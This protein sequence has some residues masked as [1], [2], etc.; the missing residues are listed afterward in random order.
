ML[1]RSRAW[2]FIRSGLNNHYGVLPANIGT[3]GDFP[4]ILAGEFDLPADADVELLV[5]ANTLPAQGVFEIH[6]DGSHY[7]G[8]IAA[9]P[10]P[11]TAAIW[12]HRPG[13]AAV[14]EA[15]G[16]P[17]TINDGDAGI[18][19]A[20]IPTA[21]AFGSVEV[22]ATIGAAG[23][24]SAEAFGGPIV[25][26]SSIV[27]AGIPSAEALG[28]PEVQ[29][30]VE[31]TGIATAEAV[32]SPSV[33]ARLLATGIGSAEA[34]GTPD[35]HAQIQAAGVA[36]AEAFGQPLVGDLPD[37]PIICVGIESG[38]A[39]GRPTIGARLKT[40]GRT[41]R[42]GNPFLRFQPPNQ[43]AP[44]PKPRQPEPA[45]AKAAPAAPKAGG[46][47]LGLLERAAAVQAAPAPEP[48]ASVP[49]QRVVDAIVAAAAAAPA[50]AASPAPKP[51]P[52]SAPGPDATMQRLDR[53]E[54]V[55]VD[56]IAQLEA[57][58][59]KLLQA[60]ALTL[61][62]GALPDLQHVAAAP[63]VARGLAI[64]PEPEPVDDEPPTLSR[65]DIAK[66]NA[67]RARI[68]ARQLLDA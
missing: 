38:E 10:D 59:D 51:A 35:I 24:A 54:G 23:I 17:V 55:V 52:A 37:H 12:Y 4:N 18:T 26:L 33:Q 7:H 62:M 42:Q 20:G 27:A 48:A 61:P 68:L 11:W 5:L 43:R 19:A 44:E 13:N 47:L 25:G 9:P 1:I 28:A 15:S 63:P 58:V 56:R 45:L 2:G 14:L 21:E 57:T 32:G 46:L 64:E 41:K 60:L 30:V 49:L 6:S 65:E 34:L 22:H 39:C 66:E 31:S 16:S 40:G 29:S 50:K 67:R 8:P 36:S 53:F 3:G